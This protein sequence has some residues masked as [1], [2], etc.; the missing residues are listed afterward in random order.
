MVGKSRNE[1]RHKGGDVLQHVQELLRSE[2][3]LAGAGSIHRLNRSHALLLGDTVSGTIIAVW[4]GF[5]QWRGSNPTITYPLQALLH[6]KES[7][8]WPGG[9]APTWH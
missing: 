3:D 2:I 4:D 9:Q 8:T 5:A 1:I 6:H 7:I